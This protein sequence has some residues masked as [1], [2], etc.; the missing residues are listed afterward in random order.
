MVRLR[1]IL[2]ILVV[3][4]G[5]FAFPL[6][7]SAASSSA[8]TSGSL[9]RLEQ[10]Q[11][12]DFSGQ[13]LFREE[14]NSANMTNTNFNNANLRGGVLNGVIL[15][16]ANLHGVDFRQGIAYLSD[17]KGA[18]LSD[19]IF[20]DAMMLR[21]VFSD[22]NVTNADF[23]NAVLDI[24]QVKKLCVNASGVNPKTGVSTRES[25]GCK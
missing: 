22:V 18:D 11:N 25:L 8:V 6:V 4:V 9:M 3:M 1:Q 19:G 13:D 17:F 2:A 20:A 21:S 15:H 24:T 10:L 14:F 23:S 5:L 16:G 7:A 12:K